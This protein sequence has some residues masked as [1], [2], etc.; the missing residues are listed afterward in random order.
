MLL[1]YSTVY[2]SIVMSDCVPVLVPGAAP[3]MI[4][5]IPDQRSI[6]VSFMMLD[7]QNHH[8]NITMYEVRYTSSNFENNTVL[9]L[10]TLNGDETSLQVG[11]LEE[12]TNYTVEVRA[13][14][15]IGPGPYSAPLDV[16]TL[17]DRKHVM[18]V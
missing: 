13:Y 3:V 9:T 4:S 7:C 17:P 12:F 18:C 8:G 14:T 1:L 15:V 16:L 11:G 6:N 5:T 10:N 2:M